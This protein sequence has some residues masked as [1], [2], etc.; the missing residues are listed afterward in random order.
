MHKIVLSLVFNNMLLNV[1]QKKKINY[2]LVLCVVKYCHCGP[3][4]CLCVVTNYMFIDLKK[5]NKY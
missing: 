2:H 1:K 5:K 4:T 3:D